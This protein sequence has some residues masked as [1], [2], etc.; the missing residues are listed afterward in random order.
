MTGSNSS[1]GCGPPGGTEDG[2]F[3]Y[4][5]AAFTSTPSTQ[6]RFSSSR[7]SS[8]RS[9][10]SLG[11]TSAI[12]VTSSNF[13]RR[14][15]TRHA[16]AAFCLNRWSA[17]VFEPSH[18]DSPL[19]QNMDEPWADGPAGVCHEIRPLMPNSCKFNDHKMGER[20]ARVR[21]GEEGRFPTLERSSCL[22]QRRPHLAPLLGFPQVIPPTTL[23]VSRPSKAYGK[24]SAC[25]SVSN[26]VAC[27]VVIVSRERML[28]ACLAAM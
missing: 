3:S 2:N 9:S 23:K 25:I 5:T 6:N 1:P 20:I 21:R 17:V 12:L 19:G 14:V 18:N 16:L 4:A 8:P 28:R 27:S 10:R 15:A 24:R 13:S 7:S 22:L 11:A 26:C